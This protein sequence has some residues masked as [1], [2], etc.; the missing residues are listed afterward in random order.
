MQKLEQAD[1]HIVNEKAENYAQVASGLPNIAPRR[2]Q[3]LGDWAKQPPGPNPRSDERHV[4]SSTLDIWLKLEILRGFFY[5]SPMASLV[6]T[7]SSQLTTKSFEK[8]PDQILYPYA[9]PYDLQ[10]HFSLLE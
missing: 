6:Q 1:W 4:A 3:G 2:L 5:S 9:E 10:K 8:L 7:D